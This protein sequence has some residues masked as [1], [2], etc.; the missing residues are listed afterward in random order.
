MATYYCY[1]GAAGSGTGADWTNAYTTLTAALASKTAS[2]LIYI[3]SDHSE[4]TAA[5]V[6]LT[7]PATNGLR[8]ISVDRGTGAP[9]AGATVAVGA[10]S[11]P[12][13]INGHAYYFGVN[14]NSGTNSA[15]A[16]LINLG[17]ASTDHELYFDTCSFYMRAANT[18]MNVC[19][20]QAVATTN[21][22]VYVNCVNCDFRLS[23]TGQT[24]RLRNARVEITGM[25]INASGSIPTSLF[26]VSSAMSTVLRVVASDLTGRSWTNLLNIG[27]SGGYYH[28]S[29]CKFP[30]SWTATSHTSVSKAWEL[31]VI[32]CANGDTHTQFG[33]YTP[34]GSVV[35]DTAN[36][37]TAGAAGVSWK[38]TT[39]SACTP[40]APFFTPWIDWYHTGTSSITP[41]FE[42]LRNNG[43]ATAYSND[44]VAAEFLAKT[45]S[46][47]PK[48]SLSTDF[49]AL[50]GTP[51]AQAAGV[52]TGS[53]TIGSSNSPNS[54]KCDSGSAI[55]PAESGH[56][57]GRL[58]I[59]FSVA[60]TLYV[61]PQILV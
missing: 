27:A 11:Q 25:T 5:A 28:F 37:L 47:V 43:T 19:F 29:Q 44:Q 60:G 52:G 48:S 40:Q 16:T 24:I 36:Y 51:A 58:R 55:T 35:S 21:D 57:R 53:W 10:A 31:W 45:T 30:S 59:G 41:Y 46:G 18:S 8:V 34:I 38:I 1:S 4:S 14:F 56:I 15:T 23:A 7:A 33:Y 54:F 3:A 26:T 50:L 2:D 6:T 42:C 9:T 61:N 22:D 13:N 49:V 32:D 17:G 20:G 39:T 12:I